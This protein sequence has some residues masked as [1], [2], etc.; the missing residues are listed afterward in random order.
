L[1]ADRPDRGH[2]LHEL[3]AHPTRRL[4]HPARTKE[5][6]PPDLCSQLRTRRT[7][8]SW[9]LCQLGRA[10]F[11]GIHSRAAPSSGVISPELAQPPTQWPARTNSDL[12]MPANV[13]SKRTASRPSWE[14]VTATCTLALPRRL[15]VRTNRSHSS[16]SSLACALK[17]PR[18]GARYSTFES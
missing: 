17:S 13:P 1:I 9:G 5:A 7:L 12:L 15:R 6:Q 18:T 14:I 3:E 2:S 8:R 16:A 10:M 4:D 11:A